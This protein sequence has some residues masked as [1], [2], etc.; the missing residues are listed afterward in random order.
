[1]KYL[2]CLALIV[3]LWGCGDEGDEPATVSPVDAVIDPA[4][5]PEVQVGPRKNPE[6]ADRPAQRP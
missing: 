3:V 2:V 6:D 1:M 5:K 4:K